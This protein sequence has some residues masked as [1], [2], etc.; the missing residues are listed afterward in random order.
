[1]LHRMPPWSSA[2]KFIALLGLALVA[3]VP[4]S[5]QVVTTT[6][7]SG[8]GSLRHAVLTAAPGATIT[9]DPALNGVTIYLEPNSGS[10]VLR[11][12]TNLVLDA[13]ALPNGITVALLPSTSWPVFEVLP[14]ATVELKSLQIL[15][16]FGVVNRGTLTMTA[17][18][19]TWS[20]AMGV[21][22]R[23]SL[24]L[25][26]CMITNS[27]YSGLTNREQGV[28][29]VE[30]STLADNGASGIES[31]GSSLTVR[32]CAISG[33]AGFDGGLL[34][35][36]G[37]TLV[38]NSSIYSNRRGI[39]N[40]GTLHL[41]HSTVTANTQGAPA[42]INNEGSLTLENSIVAN[43]ASTGNQDIFGSYT[44]L[45]V[46]IVKLQS[47]STHAG[48][49]TVLKVDA[50]LAAPGDFGGPTKSLRPLPTS[51]AL[52]AIPGMPAAGAVDQRGFARRAGAA[53]DIGAVELQEILVTTAADQNDGVDLN[54]VSLRE[55]LALTAPGQA[56]LIRF[57][58]A[59]FPAR[60]P[61]GGGVLAIARDVAIDARDIAG[62]VVIDGGGLSRVFQVANLKSLALRGLS[63]TGGGGTDGG[64]VF[65]A[66]DSSGLVDRCAIHSNTAPRGGGIYNRGTLAVVNSTI[67]GNTATIDGGGIYSEE[68]ISLLHTTVC[69]NAAPL[70]QA[71]GIHCSG[72]R[73]D[74]RNSIVA[75]NESPAIF[76]GVEYIDFTGGSVYFA[77]KNIVTQLDGSGQ[78]T[79][80]NSMVM[81]RDPRLAPLGRYGTAAPSMPPLPGS[82]A[83]E[84]GIAGTTPPT[85]DQHGKPRPAGALPDIGAVE[86]FAWST[87]DLPSADGDAIPDLLEGEG[88]AYAQLSPAADDSATDTDGDGMTDADELACMTDPGDPKDYFRVIAVRPA[89][90]FA[91]DGNAVLE[92]T[93]SSF[94]GLRYHLA[95][96][97]EP[98]DTTP[99]A[100]SGFTAEGLAKTVLVTLP[101]GHPFVEVRTGDVPA[102]EEVRRSDQR[103]K[104]PADRRAEERRGTTCKGKP[105]A[106]NPLRFRGL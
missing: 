17:C 83:I 4:A 77:G 28:L 3:L 43:N 106:G 75:K 70:F 99:L 74:L 21:E 80:P 66:T 97:V 16:G 86:A 27:A 71:A 60:I 48:T 36:T 79:S 98:F 24:T 38:E 76:G 44:A 89:A 25:R 67:A 102:S 22:N 58:P 69:G 93:L 45:G 90:G 49:G 57:D 51:P 82:P 37:Q 39:T 94:P 13:S 56:E 7:N 46:N 47:P 100:G 18:K 34:L 42:G 64:G 62:E 85:M 8:T 91:V 63:I 88:K 52:D 92:L 73:V 2:S 54:G 5:A 65:F 41:R 32:R 20:Y 6:H 15:R 35:W 78:T 40:K 11:I 53:T 29:T 104:R 14:G 95:S 81:E 84:G 103:R 50:R 59:V 10:D 96:G 87:L 33:N 12:G 30:D 23:G 26:R 61:L 19:G 105:H 68:D 55:A 1:M 72:G 101:A 9:F 31:M